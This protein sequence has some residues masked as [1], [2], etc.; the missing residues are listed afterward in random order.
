M[1]LSK[2]PILL[3]KILDDMRIPEI[4]IILLI[5]VDPSRKSHHQ[6]L[7]WKCAHGQKGTR[8]REDHIPS[9]RT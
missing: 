9:W 2:D 7:K 8:S 6:E 5:A 3:P 4:V 1:V